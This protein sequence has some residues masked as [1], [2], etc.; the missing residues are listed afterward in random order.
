[1]S[2]EAASPIDLAAA[3]RCCCCCFLGFKSSRA[4]EVARDKASFDSRFSEKVG[5]AARRLSASKQNSLEKLGMMAERTNQ[6]PPRSREFQIQPEQLVEAGLRQ[7]RRVRQR[8]A[9]N[10]F[11]ERM[12]ECMII[13]NP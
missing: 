9:M 6:A 4:V 12:H 8:F 5:L 1:M 3:A 13:M 7:A 10:G 11:K 2:A